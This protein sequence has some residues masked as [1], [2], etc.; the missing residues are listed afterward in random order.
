M[1]TLAKNKQAYYDYEILEKI[2]AGIVLT[3]PE[4]KSV[5]AGQMNLKGSYITINNK[6]DGWLINCHISPYKP[7]QMAQKNYIPTRTRK[8][9][10]KKNE[11]ISIRTKTHKTGLTLLPLSVYTKG[12]LI[13]IEVSIV[14]GRK[15]YDKREMIKK[16]DTE[17]EMRRKM[18]K[19]IDN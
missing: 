18:R 16:R 10:M 19:T 15:K 9:L 2:E 1:P 13:K 12:D 8:L 17:R 4:V 5:K 6:N 7:A 11:L 3:G 14:K